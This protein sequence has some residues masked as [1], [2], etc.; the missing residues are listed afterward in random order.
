MPDPQLLL[1]PGGTS[2]TA[3]TRTYS[4]IHKLWEFHERKEKTGLDR[5]QWII[6]AP[7]PFD[8]CLPQRLT[9]TNL[10]LQGRLQHLPREVDVIVETSGSTSGTARLVGLST[11]ALV[12]SARATHDYLGGPGRWIVALPVHHVAG[13]QTIMRSCVAGLPPVLADMSDGFNAENLHTACRTATDASNWNFPTRPRAYLS[14]VARQLQLALETGGALVEELAKLDAILVGGSALDPDLISRARAAGLNVVTTY[15]MT[16]TGGGCVY[17]GAALPGVQ[18]RS[19]SQG[20]LQISGPMLMEGYL[21]AGPTSIFYEDGR[22]WLPTR[23]LGAVEDGRV[24]V[25][26][27]ADQVII[28][29]AVNVDPNQVNAAVEKTGLVPG[30]AFTVGLD[31]RDWGQVVAVLVES[32]ADPAELGPQLREAVKE[33][34]PAAWAPRVVACT[35][36]LPRTALDKVPAGEVRKILEAALTAGKAWRR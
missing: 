25:R 8:Q 13:L 6:V 1:T 19:D 2:P 4:A 24:Q 16:E 32:E 14:L 33:V 27:R 28:T 17:D 36:E 18:V 3:V 7:R 5:G 12:A 34:L 26:G 10:A 31:D 9:T 30:H 21:D 35:S 23:D 29:G 11:G 15:G 22:R 20:Q